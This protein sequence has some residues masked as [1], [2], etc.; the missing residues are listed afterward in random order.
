MTPSEFP[1][2]DAVI[3]T[4]KGLTP[5]QRETLDALCMGFE[6]P[7]SRQT[8]K[9]L[10]QKGLIVSYEEMMYFKDGLPPMKV[11]KWEYNGIRV[12]MA[13]CEVGSAE[14]DADV[15]AGKAEPL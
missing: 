1:E 2:Y 6:T 12:H 14:Y 10:E 7:I 3:A 8:A 13:W 15:A 5:K 4:I 9:A 11:T